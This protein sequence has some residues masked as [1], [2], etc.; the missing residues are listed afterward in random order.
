MRKFAL[1]VA[2]LLAASL[3][4]AAPLLTDAGKL[5]GKRVLA[6][7][8]GDNGKALVYDSAAG[9]YEHAFIAGDGGVLIEGPQGP[10][11]PQGPTG[12]QG[13][14]GV[15]GIQGA[16]G[17][18]GPEGPQGPAGASGTTDYN[19][20]NNLPTLG[21]AAAL[22]V[23][24]TAGTVAAGNDS[25]F[26]SVPPITT[27]SAVFLASPTGCGAG[28][29]TT[30]ASEVSQ[31][32]SRGINAS[33]IFCYDASLIEAGSATASL[34]GVNG[35]GAVGTL[36]MAA[37]GTL[38]LTGVYGAGAVGDLVASASGAGDILL[39]G[40][41]ADGAVG[42]LTVAGDGAVTLAGAAATGD[43]GTLTAS[44][45]T[46]GT[47][48]LAGISGAGAVGTLVVAAAASGST[49]TTGLD[50]APNGATTFDD[51]TASTDG[52]GGASHVATIT[53][54]TSAPSW[55]LGGG[56]GDTSGSGAMSRTM[57]IAAGDMTFWYKCDTGSL[58]AGTLHVYV[59]GVNKLTQPLGGTYSNGTWY[60]FTVPV[61]A[62]TG[63]TIMISISSIGGGGWIDDISI[64]IP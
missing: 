54:K 63:T 34:T 52:T 17:P 41:S 39:T 51:W 53:G 3:A 47:V 32:T 20:L 40:V 21:A 43:I 49:Y 10:A 64:P 8:S 7:T 22:G 45:A 6:P 24:T 60:Q 9:V 30:M 18:T 48:P 5:N 42:A 25:R 33:Y 19:A 11:G 57:D 15:Q 1:T 58:D 23:G 31:Y 55:N 27:H 35:T 56:D 44:D 36:T 16:T 29:Q 26:T 61:T 62:A 14:Q 59:G 13:P 50:G 37:G 46:D 38:S 12:P 4:Q 2:L 28:W